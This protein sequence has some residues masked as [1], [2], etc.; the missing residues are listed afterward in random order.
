MKFCKLNVIIKSNLKLFSI[1]ARTKSD[2]CWQVLER[3]LLAHELSGVEDLYA[4]VQDSTPRATKRGWQIRTQNNETYFEL[5]HEEPKGC[6]HAF[7]N[8]KRRDSNDAAHIT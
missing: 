4:G 7:T 1:Q 6:T 3:K 2:F 5:S 8:N